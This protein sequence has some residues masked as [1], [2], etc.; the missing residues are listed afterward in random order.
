MGFGPHVAR[1]P[2]SLAPRTSPMVALYGAVV[3]RPA[4]ALEGLPDER[5][6]PCGPDGRARLR[7]G[8]RVG[9]D[10][11]HRAADPARRPGRDAHHQPRA[12]P[13]DAAPVARPVG[14]DGAGRS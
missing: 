2:R 11:A 10:Q 12:A 3:A 4:L 8:H 5:G 1:D 14:D 13:P 6:R 7:T 9:P